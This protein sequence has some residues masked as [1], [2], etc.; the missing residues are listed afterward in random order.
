MAATEA[1]LRPRQFT[2]LRTLVPCG[3]L[4][5]VF[6][7]T[8]HAVDKWRRM[9]GMPFTVIPGDGRPSIRYDLRRVL[10]WAEANDK[11]VKINRATL[12]KLIR[13]ASTIPVEDADAP[14]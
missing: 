14:A 8:K 1:A 4:C 3:V 6:G 12:R 11:P 13:Q 2:V 7:V 10:T 5:E 9:R